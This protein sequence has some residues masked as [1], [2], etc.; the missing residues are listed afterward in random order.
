VI[1]PISDADVIYESRHFFVLC[2]ENRSEIILISKIQSKVHSFIFHTYHKGE[3]VTVTLEMKLFLGSLSYM[4]ACKE[5]NVFAFLT[6]CS[7]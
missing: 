5:K 1:I 6:H 4:L 7:F 3:A 2:R